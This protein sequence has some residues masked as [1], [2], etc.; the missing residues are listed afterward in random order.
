MGWGSRL[1]FVELEAA[2]VVPD[3]PGHPFRLLDCLVVA[4]SQW[5]SVYRMA[6]KDLAMPVEIPPEERHRLLCPPGTY[7][8]DLAFVQPMEENR[9]AQM[10]LV[11]PRLAYGEGNTRHADGTPWRPPPALLNVSRLRQTMGTD[12]VQTRNHIYVWG[13]RVFGYKTFRG[14]EQLEYD[15][16]LHTTQNQPLDESGALPLNVLHCTQNHKPAVPS[17]EELDAFRASG[18]EQLDV[19]FTGYATALQ[20]GD[21]VVVSKLTGEKCSAIIIAISTRIIDERLTGVTVLLSEYNGD[22]ITKG[23]PALQALLRDALV[24]PVSRLRLHLLAYQRKPRVGDRVLVV[25]G[26]AHR[27]ISGRLTEVHSDS[28]CLRPTRAEESAKICVPLHYICIDFKMGDVV[29]VI[30]G[31]YT[32]QVGFVVSIERGGYCAFYP[33]EI[34]GGRFVLVEKGSTYMQ[35]PHSAP[36]AEYPNELPGVDVEMEDEITKTRLLVETD[37]P[38]KLHPT[39]RVPTSHLVF[40]QFDSSDVQFRQDGNEL[41]AKREELKAMNDNMGW[42]I[43]KAVRVVGKHKLKGLFAEVVGYCWTAPTSVLQL[44]PRPI[45]YHFLDLQLGLT[46]DNGTH[47]V[48]YWN[49]LE[50][51]SGL[52]LETAEVLLALQ[53]AMFFDRLL[54][55]VVEV[56][57][58]G[59][60]EVQD[61]V[62]IAY[63]S[64]PKIDEDGATWLFHPNLAKKRINRYPTLNKHIRNKTIA[65][66]DKVGYVV[67]DSALTESARTTKT[68][69][70]LV[71]R[72]G[73]VIMIG[74]NVFGEKHRIGQ[75]A[76]MVPNGTEFPARVVRVR[77]AYERNELGAVV[78]QE[79]VFYLEAVSRSLRGIAGCPETF[80]DFDAIP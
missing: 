40:E 11:V 20:E 50:C 63:N 14:L 57:K 37:D 10:L 69:I 70:V 76:E 72:G 36:S 65:Q 16:T 46:A 25:G 27:G 39:I 62:F 55:P 47:D 12:A 23:L 9:H 33:A 49:V 17:E 71:L 42:L 21:R 59:L 60:E 48:P 13:S 32:G 8:R 44:L 2:I 56:P 35:T 68:V 45:R 29:R 53:S 34:H 30:R 73:R 28:V 7:R 54:P 61:P 6:W 52:P 64:A 3:L 15:N 24:V 19:P 58:T 22:P 41:P 67:L 38:F 18:A 75:Y 66:A 5:P 78:R 31:K 43:Y 51:N 77:F 74:P 79:E 26:T 1:V 80:M 4:L